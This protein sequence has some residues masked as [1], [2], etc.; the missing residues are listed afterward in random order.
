MKLKPNSQMPRTKGSKNRYKRRGKRD[1]YRVALLRIFD[2]E[3]VTELE[4]LSA[5]SGISVREVADDAV[6]EGIACLRD[7]A[8][9]QLIKFR[10]RKGRVVHESDLE[11]DGAGSEGATQSQG[12]E[13]NGASSQSDVRE[14]SPVGDSRPHIIDER[15]GRVSEAPESA[16]L[17]DPQEVGERLVKEI[18]SPLDNLAPGVTPTTDLPL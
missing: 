17:P 10:K 14:S 7:D 2:R 5:E 4:A 1:A 16:P 3:R 18:V 15:S 6:A 13:S 9:K 8:Y 11:T 12:G